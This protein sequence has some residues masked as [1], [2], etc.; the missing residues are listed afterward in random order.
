MS[1]LESHVATVFYSSWSYRMAGD[2][3]LSPTDSGVSLKITDGYLA[4]WQGLGLGYLASGCRSRSCQVNRT[5]GVAA[6][7]HLSSFLRANTHWILG[8]ERWRVQAVNS[9]RPLDVS[10]DLC[11]IIE[12]LPQPGRVISTKIYSG[13]G[14]AHRSKAKCAS[15]YTVI[16]S[17]FC[18]HHPFC[19][20]LST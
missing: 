4:N 11:L 1:F 8:R 20:D 2:G 3:P 18:G 15:D 10:T 7:L 16:Q 13:T 6:T 12:P 5:Q 17:G 9:L 19:T 14:E